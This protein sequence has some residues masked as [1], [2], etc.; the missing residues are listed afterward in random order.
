MIRRHNK[1]KKFFWLTLII[2]ILGLG[3]FLRPVQEGWWSVTKSI[4]GWFWQGGRYLSW[5]WKTPQLLNQRDALLAEKNLWL[6]EKAKMLNLE[7]ENSTLRQATKLFEL[8]Q[9]AYL[10]A[11]VIAK[12]KYNERSLIINRGE[13]NGVKLGQV[14]INEQGVVLGKVVEVGLDR[15]TILLI[16]DHKSQLAVAINQGITL[17]L[18]VGSLGGGLII[19]YIP[20]EAKV[21]LNQL[22]Y[23]S[24]LEGLI[25]A[26][27]IVG[28]ISGLSKEVG[29]LFQQAT[30]E[31]LINFQ[32]ISQ[33][34]L[35]Q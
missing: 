8:N 23:T 14:F 31:S 26:G 15:S 21:E 4:Q 18:A 27:L 22:V 20:L 25:P 17:G 32:E 10:G 11:G 24:G 28:K 9:V 5:W 3:G 6:S 7:R 33:G 34:W 12:D 30:V 2:L 35:L 13:R 29:D 16:S 19:N 1:A